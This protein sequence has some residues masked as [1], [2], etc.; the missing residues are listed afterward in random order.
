MSKP[1]YCEYSSRMSDRNVFPFVGSIHAD[2]LAEM[3]R[4][5]KKL[6]QR[7]RECGKCDALFFQGIVETRTTRHGGPKHVLFT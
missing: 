7:A 4:E 3:R 6:E 5:M 1:F 2:T